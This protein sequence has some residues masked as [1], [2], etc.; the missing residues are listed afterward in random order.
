[1][2]YKISIL[3]LNFILQYSFILGR[4]LSLLALL[5]FYRVST[6]RPIG[7]AT[8]SN[9][10]VSQ[11]CCD[12]QQPYVG[13]KVPGRYLCAASITATLPYRHP[14]SE[15]PPGTVCPTVPTPPPPGS[16]TATVPVTHIPSPPL[17]FA[18]QQHRL[19]P[20]SPDSFRFPMTE[21]LCNQNQFPCLSP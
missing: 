10:R 20:P 18:S 16:T 3:K 4:Y 8:D 14:L 9:K 21:S 1:M 15:V 12:C 17:V 6:Q 13:T 19:A 2:S 11:Q 5:L 7:M